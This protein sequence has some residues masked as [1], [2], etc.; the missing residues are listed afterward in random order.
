MADV[1]PS[2][3]GREYNDKAPINFNNFNKVRDGLSEERIEAIRTGLKESRRIL[4]A[5]SRHAKY[6]VY[7]GDMTSVSDHEY[8]ARNHRALVVG[9]PA[10]VEYQARRRKT[11][12]GPSV[13]TVGSEY[14]NTE[15][16]GAVLAVTLNPG[17][18]EPDGFI[19]DFDAKDPVEEVARLGQSVT[20]DG[21]PVPLEQG[22][23]LVM[24]VIIEA[25]ES[26]H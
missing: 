1:D 19:F 12:A 16:R 5:A 22:V 8:K 2:L 18:A 9:S 4:K 13:E 24:Q 6:E 10:I 11:K 20:V 15:K 7:R 3:R 26:V 17:R 14:Q 25:A 21:S 23:D